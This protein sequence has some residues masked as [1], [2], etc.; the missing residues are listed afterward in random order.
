M[1]FVI[2]CG[3][4]HDEP[5]VYITRTGKKYHNV[6]CNYLSASAIPIGKFKA[7]DDGYT[8]CLRCNGVDSGTIA[9]NN[10]G[11]SFVIS[12]G[13]IFT[14]IIG[15]FVICNARKCSSSI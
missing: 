3:F 12:A 1:T 7:I 6:D 15:G 8:A 10:Y 4:K 9:V 2:N 14:C 11:A 13:I 5:L